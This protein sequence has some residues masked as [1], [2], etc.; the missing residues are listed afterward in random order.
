MNER[1]RIFELVKKGVISSEEALVL[2]ENLAT[3]K[4]V[5]SINHAADT[6]QMKNKTNKEAIH[7]VEEEKSAEKADQERLEKILDQLVQEANQTSVKLDGINIDL[8]S[9]EEKINRLEE[10]V[11]VINTLE[12]LESL[13]EEKIAERLEFEKELGQLKQEKAAKE[14]IK[15]E[16]ETELRAIKKEHREETKDNWAQKFE[17][18]EDWERNVEDFGRKIGETSDKLGKKLG[19]KGLELGNLLK[20]KVKDLSN[21]V[22][23]NVEW[24]DISMKVPGMVSNSFQHEFFYPETTATLIDVK[25]ANGQVIFKSWDSEDVKVEANIKLY[26]KMEAD[27]LFEAFLERSQ[28]DV[29]DEK[30]SFQVPN[31]RIK[32]DLVFYLP[33]RMY[34]HVSVNMLNGDVTFEELEV[35]DAFVKSTNGDLTFTNFNAT[36]LEVKG[37]NGDVSITDSTVLD[38]IG[39]S[40]NGDYT[41]VSA[42][43]NIQISNVNGEVKITDNTVDTKKIDVKLVNGTIKVALPAEVGFESLSKTNTGAIKNRLTD[44][45]IVREKS[46]KTNQLLQ[47]RRINPENIVTI[48]LNTTTGS[49]Y[50]KNTDK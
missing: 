26:G 43:K 9:I 40:V 38:F 22:N 42:I 47:I 8:T 12:E 20:A 15:E 25:V 3:T 41:M 7:L 36:M 18:P 29:T 44:F 28:I 14:I 31:K 21:Q 13:S 39:E 27:S 16:L 50:L 4:D 45:E 1:E 23:E 30:I 48:N 49:I 33:K 19:E 32:A 11:M 6:L 10:Q 5:E 35:K 17:I 34:D 46:E 37:V 24:K 2:L